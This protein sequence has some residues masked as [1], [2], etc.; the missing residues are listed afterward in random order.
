MAV[1]RNVASKLMESGVASSKAWSHHETPPD[2]RKMTAEQKRR[3]HV[4]RDHVPFRKDCEQCA[5][6]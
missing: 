5:M 1:R 4:D 3:L 2:L 6:S